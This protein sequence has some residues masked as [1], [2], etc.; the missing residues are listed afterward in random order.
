V[1]SRATEI[2]TLIAEIDN[3]LANKGKRLSRVLSPQQGQEP[4]L[5]L[6]RIRIFLLN[7]VENEPQAGSAAQLT[8]LL[9]RYI[10]SD[11]ES[12]PSTEGASSG[13][14]MAED[15]SFGGITP[16]ASLSQNPSSQ[17]NNPAQEIAVLIEP[18]KVELRSLLEERKNLVE[19]IR[20]LE[21]QRLHNYSLVQQMATQEQAIADFLQVLANR[22]GENPAQAT[23][24]VSVLKSS[25]V[26]SLSPASPESEQQV[27]RLSQ[28]A[29]ELDQKLIA[30]DGTVNIVFEAL[31]RNVHTHH[32][33]LSEAMERMRDRG[34]QGEQLLKDFIDNLIQQLQSLPAID[35]HSVGSKNVQE[36]SATA[37]RDGAKHP[38]DDE[39]TTSRQANISQST[40]LVEKV[41]KK[42]AGKSSEIST[43]EL[44]DIDLGFRRFTFGT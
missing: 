18:L 5:V 16:Q 2:Q 27:E 6:E 19:E 37:K 17:L 30:L 41:I 7:L 29:G 8:P 42:S 1:T 26:P 40:P 9:A 25:H 13:Y 33:S 36:F 3:L 38:S 39:R 10:G 21:Q 23:N 43:N 35:N 34:S 44:P 11:D 22:V 4:K 28:L 20:Q 24:L 15:D 31:Q 12:L 32:D 14:F